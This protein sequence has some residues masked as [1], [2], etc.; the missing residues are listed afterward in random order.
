MIENCPIFVIGVDRSGTTLLSLML[1]SHPRISIPY[2][3][4]FIIDYYRK[5][6][7]FGDLGSYFN[8]RQLIKSVLNEP[9]VREWEHQISIGEVDIEKCNS[10][11]ES[12]NQIYLA[13]AQHF[14][15]DIWGDKTPQYTSEIAILNQ[16]FPNS[17]FIHLVRD[18]RDVALSLVKQW[19]G[20]NDFVTAM[21]Y[22]ATKV[23]SAKKMLNMLPEEQYIELKFEDLV[24]EPEDQLKR[25]T[26]FLKVDYQAKMLTNYPIKARD[27]VGNRI[28]AHHVN[29]T[30]QPL[31]SQ[32]YKWK[33]SLKPP[34]QA[35]AFEIAGSVLLG[36]GYP[37]G[38]KSH[39]LKI[40]WKGHHRLVESLKYRFGKNSP[41][42]RILKGRALGSQNTR[43]WSGT[44]YSTFEALKEKR[45]AGN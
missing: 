3:S 33:K 6:E 26:Q 12:I 8:R 28:K 5:R 22:W 15:K 31:P 43:R 10:L 16:M 42:R 45:A 32:A 25:I 29:L 7:S 35:I 17:K 36:L 39:P 20:A 18:G 9:Y 37:E 44:D 30:E 38:I 11:E 13:Y 40:L 14:G 27:K 34:N 2:E 19:W 21:K 41:L 4:H 23:T 1:D 24:S